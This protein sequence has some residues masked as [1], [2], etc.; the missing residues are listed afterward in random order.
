MKPPRAGQYAL[1]S[2]YQPFPPRIGGRPQPQPKKLF[3]S[4]NGIEGGQD[5]RNAP[6]SNVEHIDALDYRAATGRGKTGRIERLK[7]CRGNAPD[8][9]TTTT[10]KGD[11]G[12]W[13]NLVSKV[14]ESPKDRSGKGHN[15][16]SAA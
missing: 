8:E 13:L 15:L 16:G 6:V 4:R 14:R 12:R 2:N 1:K 7:M 11:A 3:C 9:S 5:A 10:I